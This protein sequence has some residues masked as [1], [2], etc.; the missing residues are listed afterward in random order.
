MSASIRD[1]LTDRE[2]IAIDQDPAGHQARRVWQHGGQEIWQRPLANG[3]SAV[4]L[5]NR[6]PAAATIAFRWTDAGLPQTPSHIRDVWR[7][8]DEKVRGAGYSAQVPGH[9]ALV[10]RVGSTDAIRSAAGD[11]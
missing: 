3:E 1:I 8:A 10:L 5:F 9:G 6:A 4:A 11:R 7:H 2:I